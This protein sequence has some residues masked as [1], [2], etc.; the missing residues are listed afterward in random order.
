MG[1]RALAAR[2]LGGAERP[3][4]KSA[5]AAKN[6]HTLSALH[7]SS[8]VLELGSIVSPLYRVEFLRNAHG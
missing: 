7:F 2:S 3:S 8:G 6:R 4:A 5:E 1:C